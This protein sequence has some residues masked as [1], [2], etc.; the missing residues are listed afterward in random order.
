MISRRFRILQTII[1]LLIIWLGESS[2][3]AATK[4]E[5]VTLAKGIMQVTT[6]TRGLSK[7]RTNTAHDTLV[8]IVMFRRPD[9]LSEYLEGLS[10]KAKTQGNIDIFQNYS[11]L[12]T[13]CLLYTSP[14]PRD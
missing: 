3:I 9:D 1:C 12:S 7:K 10:T 6:E 8:D 11:E 4:D 2:A 5:A 14:S 13:S